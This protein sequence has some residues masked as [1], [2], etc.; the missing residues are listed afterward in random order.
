MLRL[1]LAEAEI[2]RV[3]ESIAGHPAVVKNAKKR[4]KR[5]GSVLLNANLHHSAMRGLPQWERRGRPD[6]VHAFLL[7]ALD[8]IA[9]QRGEM[10]ILVHTRNDEIIRVS[11]EIRLPKGY[12]RFCG[13]MESLFQNRVVPDHTSPLLEM[14][15]M[16]LRELLENYGDSGITL[17]RPGGEYKAMS[18]YMR[19]IDLK[20]H[21]FVIGGFAVG[22]FQTDF[23]VLSHHEISISDLLLKVWTATSEVI[24]NYELAAGIH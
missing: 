1:I 4:G 19:D 11:S 13:L 7:L 5:P 12:N 18:E 23:S 20:E 15:D 10:E 8:S 6:I 16:K 24:V 21:T 2:E 3:P 14:E 9:N 17:L 22:D